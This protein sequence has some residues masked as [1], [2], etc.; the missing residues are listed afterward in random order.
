MREYV[1]QLDNSDDLLDMLSSTYD[2]DEK[3]QNKAHIFY[4]G[5]SFGAF[6]L[7]VFL[8]RKKKAYIL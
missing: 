1:L 7:M 4:P 2:Q 6:Q 8:R 5:V 3:Q